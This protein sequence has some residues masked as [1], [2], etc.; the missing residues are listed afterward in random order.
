MIF[1]P[2][3]VNYHDVFFGGSSIVPNL[4]SSLIVSGLTT[5][6][7]MLFAIPAAY[8]LARLDLPWKRAT[9]F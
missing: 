1:A 9:G 4:V 3:L 7:T 8:A 6:L 5:V 2:T